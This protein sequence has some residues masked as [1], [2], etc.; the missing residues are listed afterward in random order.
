MAFKLSDHKELLGAKYDEFKAA[1]K[2][3]EDA[4][5]TAETERDTF[6]GQVEQG[7]TKIAQLE[8][9]VANAGKSVDDRVKSVETE[10]D[11]LR[12]E[13][14]TL[15]G[16]HEKL[17]QDF[18][19]HKLDVDLWDTAREK[20]LKRRAFLAHLDRAAVKRGKDGKL[21]GV[22]DAL[23]ALKTSMPE[24]FGEAAP[25]PPP[26]PTD[27]GKG[28]PPPKTPPGGGGE[29]DIGAIVSRGLAS[30]GA[31]PAPAKTQ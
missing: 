26:A 21:E 10:R 14:D 25:A 6:K 22:D 23:E 9:Q 27:H 8:T 16:Q 11:A 1:W 17:G 7:A 20:G 30:C 19:A 18:E 13:R 28:T 5:R 3:I 4:R 29:E 31:L 2:E 24:T 15:K 12:Q